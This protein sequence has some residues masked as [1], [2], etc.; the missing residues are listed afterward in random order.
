[1][2]GEEARQL[3]SGNQEIDGS[4]DKQD[5]AKQGQ[6]KLHGASSSMGVWHTRSGAV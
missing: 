6:H 1:M 5:N 2:S 4:D 3:V